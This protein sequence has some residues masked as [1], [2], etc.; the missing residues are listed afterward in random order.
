M[1]S[2]DH[3]LPAATEAL[4]NHP[5]APRMAWIA[6]LSF[7][8]AV[9]CVMATYGMLI[10]PIEAK[11]GVTRDLSS[12]GLS[13]VLLAIAL[14]APL[15]G[16]FASRVSI[17]LMMIA[18]ALMMVAG[19]VIAA[20]ATTITPLLA[21]YGLLIGPAF[22]LTGTMLPSVLVTRWYQVNRGRALGLV[23]MPILAVPVSPVVAMIVRDHG[24][25][26][27]YFLLAG[28]MACLLIPLLFVVDHPPDSRDPADTPVPAKAIDP[29]LG[30]R[31]LMLTGRFWTLSL[32]YAAVMTGATILSA[33]LVPMAMQWGID[34]T[35]AAT[36]LSA[37]A[38]GGMAGSVVFGWV[39]DRV[40]GAAT[41]AILCLNGAILWAATLLHPPF[42]LLVAIAAL[43][44]LHG[45]P[46]VVGISMALSQRFGPASFGRAFGLSN[47]VN[48]PFM[49]LGVPLAG[50]I[51][52]RTGSYAGAV[53]GLALFLLIGAVAAAA[54][55]AGRPALRG[56]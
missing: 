15:I 55:R 20:L 21:A 31:D 53:V 5:W 26:T 16:V 48:L 11:M 47:L 30:V 37:S 24:L 28:L 33:H 50:H 4:S 51:Y 39:A 36:L 17:R 13:L 23:N 45:A 6:F 56:R 22:C 43:L 41:L 40:G 32:G 18:G 14:T 35:R 1:S 29:G 52:V 49:V 46:V 8:V 25:S 12:L 38:L 34:A 27:T 9:G 2:V 3:G 19:F 42:A 10:G 54:G 7:N 44:G